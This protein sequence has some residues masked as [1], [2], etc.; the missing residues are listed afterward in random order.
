[1][2]QSARKGANT[3]SR[4]LQSWI[5]TTTQ[6]VCATNYTARADTEKTG[7][8]ASARRKESCE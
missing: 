6:K 2:N 4:T 3:P 8:F 1:M 5:F 7:R